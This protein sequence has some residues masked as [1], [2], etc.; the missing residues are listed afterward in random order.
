MIKLYNDA[1]PA[2]LKWWTFPGGERS[3]RIESTIN[4]KFGAQIE[5]YFK[6][7]DDLIDVLLLNNALR[8]AG[9]KDIVLY[10]PYF[11][12]AR[13]DRVMVEGEP[14]A[15]QVAAQIINSCG[16]DKIIIEDPHSDVLAGMFAPG[17][18]TVKTQ[19]DL[20]GQEIRPLLR[21]DQSLIGDGDA[22]WYPNPCLVS[23]D[24]GAL[25]KIYKLSKE[26]G[27][28]AMGFSPMPV[29]EAGK[30]RDVSTGEIVATTIDKDA[31]MCYDTF[32]VVD[33]ICDGGRTFIELG[34]AIRDTKSNAKLVLC[35][36]HGI[37]SK[38]KEVLKPMFDEILCIND[39]SEVK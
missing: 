12:F 37:F 16:F 34:K 28:E 20:W 39:L 29:I 1:E 26:V 8:N 21:T 15:L 11:P 35:V 24:A 2:I 36:T 18:L 4:P 25:K 30:Q 19:W 38:G 5:C 7:S 13:Q 31:V 33:D 14:F 6:S 23:P 22:P 27:D 3:V 32:F 9:V 17:T 10:I